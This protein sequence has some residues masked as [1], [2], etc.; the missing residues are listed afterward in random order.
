[1]TGLGVQTTR[2]SAKGFESGYERLDDPP[3]NQDIPSAARIGKLTVNSLP[4]PSPALVAVTSPP[5]NSTKLR[6]S[7][8][9][10]LVESGVSSS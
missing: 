9:P 7:A 1:M 3:W 10:I 2:K 6:T 5:C 4:C 8:S